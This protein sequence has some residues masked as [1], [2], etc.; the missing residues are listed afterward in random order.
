MNDHFSLKHLRCHIFLKELILILCYSLN[1]RADSL[2]YS[3]AQ[4]SS[5]LI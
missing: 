4:S 5:L 2:S 3:Y 1:M